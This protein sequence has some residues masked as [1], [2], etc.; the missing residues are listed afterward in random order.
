MPKKANRV[1]P[2]SDDWT[3]IMKETIN[4]KSKEPVVKKTSLTKKTKEHLVQKTS[5]TVKKSLWQVGT[6]QREIKGSIGYLI[7]E[8]CLR[9]GPLRKN[10]K[11]LSLGNRHK[12]SRILLLQK[13]GMTTK[14]EPPIQ[15]LERIIHLMRKLKRF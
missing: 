13:K 4:K 5:Q 15:R 14:A 11:N 8:L 10:Q 1:N 3:G 9:R 12:S 7:V 2:I 6:C